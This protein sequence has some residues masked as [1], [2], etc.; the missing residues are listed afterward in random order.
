MTE[1]LGDDG[2]GP[3]PVVPPPLP[4]DSPPADSPGQEDV[5]GPRIAAALID[6]VLLGGLFTV[7]AAATGGVT[8]GSGTFYVSLSA[9]WLAAFVAVAGLYYFALEALSGQTVGKRLLGV[10]VYGAGRAR[11]SAGAVAGRTLLRVVDFL[12]ALYL[13]GFITIMAT[14]ARRQRIGDLAA[15]TAVA[16][17]APARRRALAAV[18]L[19]VVLLA[20]VV[21][22][23]YR[24]TSPGTTLTYQA[25]GVS[26]DYPAS[27][28]EGD[29]T[30]PSAGGGTTLWSTA[31]GPGT[32]DDG[33][34]V[35]AYRLSH[36]VTAQNID[37]G[38]P[39]LESAMQQAGMA[40]Q[41]AP[42]KITIAG[43]PALRVRVTG[44][45]AGTRLASTRV[46]AFNGTTEYVVACN[47]TAGMAAQVRQACD[48]VT[49][50]F[51]L[52][53]TVPR[54]A[55]S[56]TSG[57]SRRAITTATPSARPAQ[58][59]S[60]VSG[61]SG[62]GGLGAK[63]VPAPAGFALSQAA[64]VHNGP[65]NAARFNQHMERRIWP[66]ACI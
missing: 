39:S 47:Y 14:G 30:G 41:G 56:A 4:A 62:K 21:L 1:I 65:M 9:G 15:G 34:V 26:F 33:I 54:A 49:G 3:A 51:R 36:A 35:T 8:T 5:L 42:E 52:S 48:Q 10:Q 28:Q 44:T 11:P 57:P 27:W 23:V 32:Q 20:A 55:A 40:V 60:P 22:S 13:A 38:V 25:H 37:A 43:L 59:T 58:G 16:R 6:L 66:P 46:L 24:A 7:M 63:V 50:R 2:E 45:A 29:Y 53:R 18:P 19:A 61:T 31:V 12:P 17:A 64:D